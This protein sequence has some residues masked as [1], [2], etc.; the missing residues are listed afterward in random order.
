MQNLQH[1]A[2]GGCFV[3]RP[4]AEPRARAV[5]QHLN[6]WIIDPSHEKAQR[7][8]EQR[9]RKTRKFPGSDMAR[10]QDHAAAISLRGFD[11][12]KP[13]AINDAFQSLRIGGRKL[14]E[15]AEQSPQI[16]KATAQQTPALVRAS[17]RKRQSQVAVACAS[18]PAGKI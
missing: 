18:Q 13:F 10:E 9:E 14:A 16:L 11:V 3:D 12:L 5:D 8:I 15:H 6:L 17:L 7:M 1:L 2:R 4:I